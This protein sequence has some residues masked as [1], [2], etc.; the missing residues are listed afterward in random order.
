LFYIKSVRR[1]FGRR[2]DFDLTRLDEKI[3]FIRGENPAGAQRLPR[4]EENEKKLCIGLRNWERGHSGA[5]GCTVYGG[6][7]Y[8]AFMRHVFS[9]SVCRGAD[10]GIYSQLEKG[11]KIKK[12]KAMDGY[13]ICFRGDKII[14]FEGEYVG[15][16]VDMVY[17]GARAYNY[18]LDCRAHTIPFAPG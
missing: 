15:I 16:A 10:G 11:R 4:G 3:V 12:R 2:A 1:R 7:R 18:K 17:R 8:D 6:S 5:Y 14:A 13:R 9:V